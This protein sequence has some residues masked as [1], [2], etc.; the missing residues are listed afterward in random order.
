MTNGKKLGA[1]AAGLG[2]LALVAWGV[3]MVL[4]PEPVT[5]LELE[6]GEEVEIRSGALVGPLTVDLEVPAPPE[7]TLAL[8]ARLLSDDGRVA[9]MRAVISETRRD[10]A[11]V[12]LDPAFLQKPGRYILEVQV[13]EKSHFPLRRYA[14]EVR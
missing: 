1:A 13:V 10:R 11:R 8:E 6:V 12:E 7:G 3:V 4:P 5:S 14:I 2:A 9:Q